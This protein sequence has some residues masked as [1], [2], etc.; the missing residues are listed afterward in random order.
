M[1]QFVRKLIFVD[2]SKH[3]VEKVLNT[4]R[5]LHWEDPEIMKMMVH[6]LSCPWKIQYNHL[7]LLAVIVSGL[8]RY[9]TELGVLVVDEILE[10]VRVGLEVS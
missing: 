7:P 1:E 2:L 6:L 5:K 8:Y 9:H 4:L 3:T 10:H